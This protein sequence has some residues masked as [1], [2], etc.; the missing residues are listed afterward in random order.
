MDDITSPLL[1]L[2]DFSD[3]FGNPRRLAFANPRS[4]IVAHS[5]AEVRPALEA[6]RVAVAA[7][8]YAAGYVAYEA[9]PAFDPA[10]A[11]R[12][13]TDM[14][15]LWFG[16]FGGTLKA[17]S[18]D[19]CREFHLSQWRPAIERNAY[20]RSV[21]AIHQAIAR[22]DTYQVNYTM[23]LRARFEGDDLA[24]YRHLCAA[25]QAGFCA[26]LNI[27]CHRILSAS[28]ELFFRW[29]GHEIV[30]RPMKGT[31]RRGRWL[32]E[33]ESLSAW[34]AA[35]EKNRA[36]NVMIVDL[37][38]NDLG[39]IAEAGSVSVPNLFEIERYPTVLQMTST[40]TAR[41]RGG[42]TL[43]NIFDALFPCGSITGAP[44]IQTT[45]LIAA[46]EDSPRNV[47]CGAIGVLEPGGE[48]VFNVAIRTVVIDNQTGSAEYG[49]GGGIT[50]GSTADDEYEEALAKA[51]L[52]FEE[53]PEFDLLETLR[54][55]NGVYALLEQHLQRL[56][57]SAR[58]FEVSLPVEAVRS[59]LDDHARQFPRQTRRVRLL[60]SLD[61][62]VK[63]ES[64][65]LP[66][67]PQTSVPVALAGTPVSRSNR[68]LF[69]KTTC[70]AVYES[71]RE[72]RSDVFDVLLWNEEGELTEF[73]AGNL[74]IEIDGEC[75]TPPRESGLLAGTFRADLLDRDKIRERVLTHADLNRA[76][77][78][79]FINSVRGWVP[80]HLVP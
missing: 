37:L 41:T 57:K 15:L 58:Y 23:R 62:I 66:P 50:W 6:V 63:V 34:L 44:K 64:D 12:S 73:T 46:L 74:V 77:H 79:W 39:R 72:T 38:R 71:H 29:D 1:Q 55:E 69:H 33:D 3:R 30:T 68:F 18:V 56:A 43:E 20:D 75:W 61:G 14:P 59:A 65:L 51:S 76:A 67:Q 60:V 4:I 54:L 48:T 21:E 78:L 24:F 27:G 7:G 10:I 36:E 28:P 9:A 35:S 40:V 11:V 25:Q 19:P 2:I 52:L 26:Y 80:V 22:G 5:V 47:Y 70:R 53:R 8:S 13:G 49:V 31:V 32:E 16:L 42:T 17:T 45:R